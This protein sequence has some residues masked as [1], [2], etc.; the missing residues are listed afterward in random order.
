MSVFEPLVD[1]MP[2]WG[3]DPS[4]DE[5]GDVQAIV[6]DA[7]F[8]SKVRRLVSASLGLGHTDPRNTARTYLQ[9]TEGDHLG[10]IAI[11]AITGDNDALRAEYPAV[12]KRWERLAAEHVSDYLS[13]L[14]ARP[15]SVAS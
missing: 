3:L 10:R 7:L 1:G 5:P 9:T 8:G 15:G 2:P 11:L 12:A 6:W 14:G 4:D 13:Q